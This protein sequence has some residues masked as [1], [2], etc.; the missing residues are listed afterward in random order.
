MLP[1]CNRSDPGP[2][3]EADGSWVSALTKN[4]K[5]ATVAKP[6]A[7]R[8]KHFVHLMSVK[9]HVCPLNTA[10][11]QTCRI[12][13]TLFQYSK[14]SPPEPPELLNMLMAGCVPITDNVSVKC[15]QIETLFPT[16]GTA[17]PSYEWSTT[18]L[19][20]AR[21]H[22]NQHQFGLCYALFVF[23]HNLQLSEL[24]TATLAP[25][26]HAA[27]LQSFI[28]LDSY[29]VKVVLPDHP[30]HT[31][32]ATPH[33][34]LEENPGTPVAAIA[35]AINKEI[36]ADMKYFKCLPEKLLAAYGLPGKAKHAPLFAGTAAEALRLT[37][38]AMAFMDIASEPHTELIRTI[39][40]GL[41]P[42][43]SALP[44]FVIDH[45]DD[46]SFMEVAKRA[47][48]ATVAEF[49]EGEPQYCSNNTPKLSKVCA[50]GHIVT[51]VGN[52]RCRHMAWGKLRA[53][54]KTASP[55][56]S[57]PL[58]VMYDEGKCIIH[59]NGSP[60]VS[61]AEPVPWTFYAPVVVS[62]HAP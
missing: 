52:Y 24:G 47:R 16:S 6:F 5:T 34:L 53:A 30:M 18:L 20:N 21:V 43:V 13:Q 59:A 32:M 7:T 2:L 8:L 45:I 61:V 36:I 4:I 11:T 58:Y 60:D 42:S 39:V 28:R 44:S 51:A 26:D 40:N 3:L 23:D 46:N 35:A 49:F 22:C 31:Y 50:I 1:E 48:T 27:L 9:E 29:G 54:V 62:M 38:G 15:A 14:Q 33:Q 57:G 12:V 19:T 56:A 55:A 41:R 10:Y 37:K 17:N 25:D